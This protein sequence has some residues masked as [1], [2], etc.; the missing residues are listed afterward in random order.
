VFSACCQGVTMK[1]G[2]SAADS[3]R[4][5][6]AQPGVSACWTAPRNLDELRAN[7]AVLRDPT[8]SPERLAE[9]RAFG[10]AAYPPHR[11]FLDGVRG[12]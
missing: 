12:R 6:L 5:A 4:Y 8:M 9:L 1:E 2:V 10:A 11:A 3:Y 7:L